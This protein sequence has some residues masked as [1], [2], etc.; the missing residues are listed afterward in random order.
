[1]TKRLAGIFGLL[2]ALGAVAVVVIAIWPESTGNGDTQPA[3][4]K[5]PLSASRGAGANAI[6]GDSGSR[7][8]DAGGRIGSDLAAA[9]RA[10]DARFALQP[11]SGTLPVHY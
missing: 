5:Q 1:M 6:P 8:T 4:S 2:L 11:V 3:E 7:S 10:G 9:E